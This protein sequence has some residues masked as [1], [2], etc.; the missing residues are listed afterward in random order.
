[1]LR[2]SETS[3]A[4]AAVLSALHAQCFE[5][6]WGQA[7]FEELLRLPTTFGL[8]GK[9]GFILCS[10]CGD[11]AEILTICVVPTYRRKGVGSALLSQ[12]EKALQE[13]KIHS[14]FLEVEE[15][16]ISALALYQSHGFEQVGRRKGYYHTSRG[17][18]DALILKKTWL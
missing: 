17:L 6:P 13:K 12:M 16:N 11:E 18:K 15:E 1:M 7:D 5:H 3:F 4:F 2:F 9:E 10:L 8:V 14:L